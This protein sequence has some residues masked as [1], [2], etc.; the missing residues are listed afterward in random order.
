MAESKYLDG[1]GLG[2]TWEK[3]KA[4]IALQFATKLANVTFSGTGVITVG[5]NQNL[6]GPISVDANSKLDVTYTS[7][8]TAGN[9]LK[10][11]DS[12]QILFSKNTTDRAKI[13]CENGIVKM[14][15]DKYPVAVGVASTYT[16]SLCFGIYNLD[17]SGTIEF[18]KS[19]VAVKNV[20]VIAI[21][22]SIKT[23]KVTDYSI[24][25]SFGSSYAHYPVII[26]SYVS[27]GADIPDG[28]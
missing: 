28:N 16:G 12:S 8:P 3:I 10:V 9:L 17:N 14:E 4:Y 15:I 5:T 11:N 20:N 18:R 26:I 2:R 1:A 13:K 21:C 25:I 22:N 27:D 23:Y 19:Q 6:S 24:D 7:T